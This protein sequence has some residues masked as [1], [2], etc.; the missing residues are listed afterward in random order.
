MTNVGESISSITIYNIVNQ[1][2]KRDFSYG[3]VV[4]NLEDR[5]HLSDQMNRNGFNPIPTKRDWNCYT[6]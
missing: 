1:L 5:K 3:S 2:G 6:M 4:N